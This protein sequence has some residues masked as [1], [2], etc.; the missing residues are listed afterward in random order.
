MHTFKL[1]AHTSLLDLALLPLLGVFKVTLVTEFH[2]M[3]RLVDF[4]L[5]T[6]QGAFDGLSVADLN[7]DTDGKFRGGSDAYTETDELSVLG[8][9]NS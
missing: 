5:E 7:L 3:P 1:L 6:T 9:K 8:T 2:Q 4:T